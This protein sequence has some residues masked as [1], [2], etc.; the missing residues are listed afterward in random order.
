M[1]LSFMRIIGYILMLSMDSDSLEGTNLLPL[2]CRNN[3]VSVGFS[4]ATCWGVRLGEFKD[5]MRKKI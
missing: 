3:K 1:Q 4:T 2:G 5:L